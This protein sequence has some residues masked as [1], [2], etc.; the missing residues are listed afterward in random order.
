[1]KLLKPL[2]LPVTGI[3]GECVRLACKCMLH[4]RFA[5]GR[6]NTCAGHLRPVVDSGNRSWGRPAQHCLWVSLWLNLALKQLF[7]LAYLELAVAQLLR[8]LWGMGATWQS[9]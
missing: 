4:V 5:A 2:A 9:A 7:G 6:I 1:M 8:W 3:L